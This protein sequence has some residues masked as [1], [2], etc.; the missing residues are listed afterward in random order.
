MKNPKEQVKVLQHI[1][2]LA[3]ATTDIP[4]HFFVLA[5]GNFTAHV[6]LKSVGKTNNRRTCLSSLKVQLSHGAILQA[7]SL[8]PYSFG[9]PSRVRP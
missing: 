5:I 4:I 1:K 2:M 7:F 8:R 9:P 6:Q 3:H